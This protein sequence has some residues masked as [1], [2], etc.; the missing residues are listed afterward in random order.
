MISAVVTHCAGI[1]IGKKIISVC[2]MVGPADGEP[3]VVIREYGTFTADLEAMKQ[4]LVQA[5]CTH[6]VMESTGSYWKPVF[7]VL[8]G[9][10]GVCLANPE[11]VKARKGHKTDRK[12]A[13]WLAH[14]LRHG[15]V[16]ASFVPPRPVRELRDLTR[17]RKQL[18]G[19]STSERNR[20]QKTLEDASVKLGNVLSD[21]FGVSGQRMLEALLEGRGT[22]E[23]IAK[24]A[25]HKARRKIPELIASLEGH[26]MNEHHRFMIRLSLAHLQ[27]LEEQIAKLDQQI[28]QRLDQLGWNRLL[29][30]LQTIPGI[31]HDSAATILAEV[32]SDMNQ[33]PTDKQM[34]SWAG[35]CPGNKKSAGK[36]FRGHTTRGNRWLRAALTECAWAASKA[37]DSPL[38]DKF[39]RLAA[40]SKKK[41]VIAV[42]HGL[43]IEIRRVL[44]TKQPSHQ[45]SSPPVDEKRRKRMIRHHL[46]CL[47]R[48]GISTGPRTV[49]SDG[50]IPRRGRPLKAKTC[51]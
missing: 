19:D 44:L 12:D 29:D 1:D 20:I 8:E 42:A 3:K 32:G 5:G 23:E 16:R 10:M 45:R 25:Q 41:A 50:T 21:V 11:D 49:Y 51:N 17:R 7:N 4:W 31:R 6:V 28:I 2:L 36:N 9:S 37:K 33:F 48:L 35:V 43:L 15:M 38:R 26:R 39:W 46:R 13:W 22:A 24:L 47:G 14:L 27:V 30:L 34:S 18:L 40:G